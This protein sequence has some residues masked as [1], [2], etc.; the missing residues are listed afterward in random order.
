MSQ[1]LRRRAAMVGALTL[2]ACLPGVLRAQDGILGGADGEEV[3]RFLIIADFEGR[4]KPAPVAVHSV[5]KLDLAWDPETEGDAGR[6]CLIFGYRSRG[7]GDFSFSPDRRPV[8]FSLPRRGR[9][10]R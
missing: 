3:T 9:A 4:F 7:Y 1:G 10:P 6:R 5:R 2:L 8:C